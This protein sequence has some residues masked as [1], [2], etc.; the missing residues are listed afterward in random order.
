MTCSNREE[1]YPM[2]LEIRA[3]RGQT[4]PH[5]AVPM[6]ESFTVPMMAP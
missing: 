2:V 1:N 3:K 4:R 5:D 6:N